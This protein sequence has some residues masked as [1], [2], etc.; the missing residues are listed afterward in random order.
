[1]F[2]QIDLSRGNYDDGDNVKFGF[3]VVFTIMMLSWG[4]DYFIKAHPEP[5]VLYGQVG[6]SDSDHACWMSPE[7]MTTPCES[8]MIDDQ[9]RVQ[10]SPAR[11]LPPW[12]PLPSRL[13][14]PTRLTLPNSSCMQSKYIVSGKL[15]PFLFAGLGFDALLSYW[16]LFDFAHNHQGLYQ[17]SIPSAGGFY[18]SSGFQDELVWAAPWLYH[19]TDDKWYPDFL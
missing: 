12:W 1:M 17:S 18:A 15:C 4:T 11:P 10:T 13:V 8:F 5:D 2:V 9:T 6:E 3:P 14:P 16:Q 19:A 7:D